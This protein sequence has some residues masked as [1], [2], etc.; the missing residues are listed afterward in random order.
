VKKGIY[1]LVIIAVMAYGYINERQVSEPGISSP[2]GSSTAVQQAYDNRQSDIQ[3][4]GEGIVIGVLPDDVD[5]SR[6]Q[7]FILELSHGNSLLIAHNIDLAPRVKGLK[8][9]DKIGF[10]GE[11]E[12]NPKGGVLHWT[13]HDPADRQAGGR[14]K[15]DGQTYQ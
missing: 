13:H 4:Q 9:G 12:W 2:Q 11:Y 6:H 14:L 1:V 8:K 5:G 10:Y 15:H 7:R 3:V